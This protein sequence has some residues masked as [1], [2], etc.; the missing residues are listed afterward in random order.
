LK[1]AANAAKGPGSPE[2]I[3]RPRA[4]A[5]LTGGEK[6]IKA[7]KDREFTPQQETGTLLPECNPDPKASA[8]L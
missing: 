6:K 7:G 4:G 2:L 3:V 5:I 1:S 8:L